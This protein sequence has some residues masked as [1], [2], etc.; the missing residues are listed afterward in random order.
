MGEPAYTV[1]DDP[2]LTKDVDSFEE[3]FRHG[4]LRDVRVFGQHDLVR[5]ERLKTARGKE[6]V[7]IDHLE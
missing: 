5:A 1:Q 3:V 7:P 6:F 4:S 2:I